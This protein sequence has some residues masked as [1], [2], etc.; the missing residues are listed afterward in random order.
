[1]PDLK[2]ELAKLKDL[3]FDDDEDPTQ[4]QASTNKQPPNQ[5]RSVFEYIHKHPMST[6]A[7]AAGGTGLPRNRVATLV[8]QL[9]ARKLL[10]RKKMGDEPYQYTSTVDIM[11][12]TDSARLA[13]LT[14]AHAAKKALAA[15]R[16]AEQAKAA[17]VAKAQQKVSLGDV[18]AVV[19]AA[20]TNVEAKLEGFSP[21]MLVGS[22]TPF[23]ARQVYDELK[24]LFSPSPA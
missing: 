13:A 5:T 10:S 22:L 17:K 3:K 19:Q 6:V 20:T 21:A 12:E 15:K 9:L 23:Q 24:K 16:R 7:E 18:T 14:K 11:P 8:I 2:S 1:M 4:P